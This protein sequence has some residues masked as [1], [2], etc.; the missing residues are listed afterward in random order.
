MDNTEIKKYCMI[1]NLIFEEDK[2]N[3]DEAFAELR[4]NG[5][6]QIHC[7]KVLTL[8]RGMSISEADE[9]VMNSEVWA[10][11]KSSNMKIR[12]DLSR[13]GNDI[14]LETGLNDKTQSKEN[15]QNKKSFWKKL[16]FWG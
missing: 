1:F 12:E 9:L 7:L 15:A 6:R 10:E 11:F 8:E 2:L 5:A 4:I 14:I 3:Y 13:F 16:R